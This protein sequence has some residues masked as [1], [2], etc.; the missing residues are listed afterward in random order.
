MCFT[1]LCFG[2]LRALSGGNAAVIAYCLG[3]IYCVPLSPVCLTFATHCLQIPIVFHEKKS[4]VEEQVSSFF[5]LDCVHR[6]TAS[7]ALPAQVLR[8]SLVLFEKRMH[9]GAVSRRSY[10]GNLLFACL[11]VIAVQSRWIVGKSI[12]PCVDCPIS[13]SFPSFVLL[14]LF[15]EIDAQLLQLIMTACKQDRV[16]RALDLSSMMY[17]KQVGLRTCVFPL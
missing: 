9:E 2:W 6:L 8:A 14:T 16:N 12:S 4:T 15:A 13:K 3:D 11:P 5:L 10:A 1:F 17:T 7:L